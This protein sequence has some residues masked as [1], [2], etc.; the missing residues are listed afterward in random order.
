MLAEQFAESL[1]TS[2]Q[3]P[4]DSRA[5]P[6]HLRR[7]LRNGESLQVMQFH[8]EALV[9]GQLDQRLSEAD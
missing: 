9:V 8:S 5:G 7:D 4:Y 6:R 2:K 3:E 1:Q